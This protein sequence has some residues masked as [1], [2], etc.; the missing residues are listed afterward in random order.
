MKLIVKGRVTCL[1]KVVILRRSL[2]DPRQNAKLR[3]R[4]VMNR[5]VVDS[6]T[7]ALD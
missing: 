7:P 5:E 6:Y 4:L 1:G 2:R 3:S